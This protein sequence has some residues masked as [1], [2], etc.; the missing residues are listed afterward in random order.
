MAWFFA[1][2]T[3]QQQQLPQ[4]PPPPHY[5]QDPYGDVCVDLGGGG[6]GGGFPAGGVPFG[7]GWHAGGGMPP[8]PPVGGGAVTADDIAQLIC[9]MGA[10]IIT[11]NIQLR[12]LTRILQQNLQNQRQDGNQGYR[13]TKPKKD[14]T[15]ITAEGARALMVEV[16]QLEIDLGQVDARVETEVAYRQLRAF[17]RVRP[18]IF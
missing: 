15:S 16:A 2:G 13:T 7:M 5:R 9:S 1:G 14:I 10:S 6:A 8:P 11:T 18:G 17:A 4:H 3:Q 12:G